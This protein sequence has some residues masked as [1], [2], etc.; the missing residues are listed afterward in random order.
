[1]MSGGHLMRR[2]V[3]GAN[4]A[5]WVAVETIG[6]AIFALVG[7]LFIARLIG[8]QA[9]GIGAIAASAFLTID[10]PIAALFGDALLQRSGIEERHRS[11]AFWVTMGVALL[12]TGLLALAAPW[13]A[14]AIGVPGLTDMIRSLALLL[15]FSAVAGLLAA[16]ALRGRRYR[17][18]SLR[19]LLCQPLSVGAGVLAALAGWGAWAMVVQQTV[20]T[21][22]VFCLLTVLADWRPRLLLDRK[23]LG[24]LWPVAG[25]QVLA[26]LVFSGRYRIFILALGTLVAETIVAVTHIAFRLLDVALAVVNGATARLAMPRLSALQHDRIALAEAYGDLTQLQ[27]LFG[28]PIATGLAIT[29]PHLVTLLMGEPW[30][31][32]AAPAQ[33]VALAAI[34]TFLVG[35]ASAL[36]LAVGRTRINLVVQ[37]VAFAVPL[38]ALLVVRPVD[39]AGAALCWAGSSLAVPP[40]QLVLALKALGRPLGWLAARLMVPVIG[41]AGMAAAACLV[42]RQVEQTEPLTALLL[43]AGVGGAVYLTI[44][45]LLLGCRMPRALRE[46]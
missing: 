36:W 32:A 38:A 16:L 12:G 26:L 39:V 3:P 42:A 20:A 19:V 25:P 13:V 11:S 18:L 46:A 23:A 1:M 45:A 22:S 2:L 24:E 27:A 5:A 8:P 34:P 37:L 33:L 9:A 40:V 10:F 6:A 21:L 29:A 4:S 44:L 14:G 17:L 35:P 43:I 15:P 41:T 28:L 31:A 30:I 7:L